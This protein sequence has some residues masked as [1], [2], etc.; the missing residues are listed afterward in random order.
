MW[1]VRVTEWG[2]TKNALPRIKNPCTQLME[3]IKHY[4]IIQENA[5]TPEIC[6]EEGWLNSKINTALFYFSSFDSLC[7]R[8]CQRQSMGETVSFRKVTKLNCPPCWFSTVAFIKTHSVLV[9]KTKPSWAPGEIWHF[10]V[11]C[12]LLR[13]DARKG[14]CR[15]WLTK[16]ANHGKCQGEWF[17]SF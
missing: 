12:R 14:I 3:T 9:Q 11:S 15:S 8:L 5:K 7:Y 17:I 16:L 10:F 4:E 13:F 1:I 6:T 2:C